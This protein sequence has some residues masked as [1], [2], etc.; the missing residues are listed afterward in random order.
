M[1]SPDQQIVLVIGA[2][3]GLGLALVEK[4]TKSPTTRALGTVRTQSPTLQL[5]LEAQL[6]SATFLT[7]DITNEA[8]LLSAA[9]QLPGGE[10]DVLIVNAGMGAR[11]PVTQSSTDTLA[12]Y[13]DTNVLGPHR[14]IRAFLPALRA[15][16]TRKIILI[17]SS[18]GCLT[19]QAMP[20]SIG[21]A[22]CYGTS[23]A[24]LNMLAVQTSNELNR[25]GEGF[26]VVSIHPG[27]VATDMGNKVGDGGMPPAESASKILELVGRLETS[28]SAS[29]YKFDGEKMPW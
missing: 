3:R 17:S 7:A 27:W 24:A 6:P 9:Q 25:A 1:S 16:K 18:S 26:T 28:D 10:L 29:F 13:L 11:D 23:K 12:A 21:L 20:D 22:G 14:A 2:S 15:R 4:L 19:Q 8:S 5:E